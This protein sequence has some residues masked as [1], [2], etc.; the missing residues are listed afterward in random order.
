MSSDESVGDE[1]VDAV[2]EFEAMNASFPSDED[3][4]K[5]NSD[6]NALEAWMA[7]HMEVGSA[8]NDNYEISKRIYIATKST[9]I[10]LSK[11]GLQEPLPS[12]VYMIRH[13]KQMFLNDN[14]LI[15]VSPLIGCPRMESLIQLNLENNCLLS[16]P[17]SIGNLTNLVFATLH[18]NQIRAV[19]D[20][21]VSLTK[22]Q[23]MTLYDNQIQRLPDLFYL[24]K[25]VKEISF[26]DNPLQYPKVTWHAEFD[27]KS[28]TSLYKLR[29]QLKSSG[30][31]KH[32]MY[33]KEEEVV[34]A[35]R[36]RLF[37]YLERLQTA[38]HTR[39]LNLDGL[40]LTR[41]P[42]EVR[43]V[44]RQERVFDKFLP[45]APHYVAD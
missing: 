17:A 20:S 44:D 18:R 6:E 23:R 7:A 22:L 43:R 37:D 21:I 40:G 24:L 45:G 36:E 33:A 34:S 2:G 41:I 11:M 42:D 30:A 25:P 9:K 8:Y 5:Q 29:E 13:I 10:D 16:I 4:S 14:N 12:E 3:E 27:G 35:A 26:L 19:P 1:H 28:F 15:S 39:A 38:R 31:T 32:S